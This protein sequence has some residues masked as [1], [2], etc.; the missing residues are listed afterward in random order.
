M[1]LLQGGLIPAHSVHLILADLPY[2]KTACSWDSVLPLEELWVAYK[3]VLT[4]NGVVLLTA[5]EGFDITLYKSNPQWYRYKIVWRKHNFANAMLVHKQPG[6]IH[7][8]VLVFRKDKATYN[9]QMM[10]GHKPIKG[11]HDP[12]KSLGEVFRGS[13][14]GRTRL[15]STHRDNPAGTRYPTSVWEM[16][17]SIWTIPQPRVKKGHPTPKPVA[18]MEQLI[19]TYSNEGDCVLDNT[20][21]MG[22]TGVASLH[23]GRRFL[24]MEIKAA[25]FKDA[26]AHLH[27]ALAATDTVPAA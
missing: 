4:P 11:F 1:T 7:E 22:S 19:K 17:D 9:P 15:I 20:M 16:E 24:G 21:G 3:H 5:A 26:C 18:L 25:Y 6:R 12:T 2:G 13:T 27:K 14:Q 10:S 8:Y 23:T